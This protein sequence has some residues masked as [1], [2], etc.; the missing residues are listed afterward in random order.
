M[1]LIDRTGH[2]YGHL[3]VIERLPAKSK[4]DTNAR[5]FCRCDCGLGT[6]AYGQDLARGKVKSCGCWNP[7]RIMQHGMAGTHVYRVWQAMLQ[8]CENPKAQSFANYGGRGIQVCEEWHKFEKFIADMGDRPRGFSLDRI[9]VDGP[10]SKENCRWATTK[11]QN[12][13]TRRN[14][15]IEFR[16]ERRTLAGWAELYGLN[17]TTLRERLDRLKWDDL[18][19]ALTSPPRMPA[20]HEFGGEKKTL[21]QWAEA[22]GIP[23]DTLRSRLSKLGWSIEKTLTTP[24]P[25]RKP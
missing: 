25:R 8:R 3:I 14:R 22:T 20:L 11:Q 17:W 4:K 12:N 5:W 16:G 2:R 6:V 21:A 9:E 1:Q 19:A 24:H 13:N 23:L 10:Y 7:N 15:V 18:E